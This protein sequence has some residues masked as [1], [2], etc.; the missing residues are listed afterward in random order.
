MKWL[1]G[2]LPVGPSLTFLAL[3]ILATDQALS[4]L[5][6]RQQPA[7]LIKWREMLLSPRDSS[8]YGPQ[9]WSGDH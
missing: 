3:L 2:L 7:L 9:T 8:P 1:Y 4:P 5:H 6:K